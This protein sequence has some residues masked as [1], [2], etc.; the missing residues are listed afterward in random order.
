MAV[1]IRALTGADLVRAVDTLAVLRIAVF[2]EFPYLYDGSADYEAAY[3]REFMAAPG[4]RAGCG[5][6]RRIDRRRGNGIAHDLAEVRIPHAVRGSR[7]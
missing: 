5:H 4:Q 6:G 1:T 3:M 2:A 7:H